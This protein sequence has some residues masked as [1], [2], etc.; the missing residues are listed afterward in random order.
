[1]S[2]DFESTSS[3]HLS[4]AA[5]L[6]P[7]CFVLLLVTHLQYAYSQQF[8]S[9]VRE[10]VVAKPLTSNSGHTLVAVDKRLYRIL[11][12]AEP[13]SLVELKAMESQQSRVS[14][15]IQKVTVN[16]QQGAAQGSGVLVTPTG[17]ILTAAHVAGKPGRDATIVLYDGTRVRAKT[18]GMNRFLDAGL[19]KITETRAEPWPTA[20]LG[21]SK[22]LKLGQWCIAAG[23]PG[24]WNKERGAVVRV[25]RINSVLQGTLVTDCAL[26]GGDSGGPLFNLEGKLIGV[27]SRIGTD[28]GDNMHVPVD[29]Y[30]QYW[31][32]MSNGEA[33]GVLPGFKPMIGIRGMSANDEPVIESVIP[34]SPAEKAGLQTGDRILSIDDKQIETFADIQ[35]AIEASLPGERILIGIERAAQRFRLEVEVAVD[36]N[37]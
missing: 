6:G 8:E 34:R 32:R 37:S 31:S 5:T 14:Q 36:E 27:H 35:R 1:M 20:S 23:H 15:A 26:I 9:S 3:E 18:L 22:N 10:H 12:G 21:L 4:K 24:G 16:V 33:W 11:D 29:V 25:G 19:L 30:T 17:H 2:A 28:I 7:L 13:S